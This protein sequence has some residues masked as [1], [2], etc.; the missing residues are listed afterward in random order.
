L[1]FPENFLKFLNTSEEFLEFSG[2]P[3]VLDTFKDYLEILRNF[4][5]FIKIS[6]VL[7]II[8]SQLKFYVSMANF[9]EMVI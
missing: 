5:Q 4:R 1:I 8:R 2:V 3:G 7:G 9:G 6:T